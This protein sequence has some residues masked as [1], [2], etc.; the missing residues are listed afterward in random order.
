LKVLVVLG[1]LILAGLG[2]IR[3]A[4]SDPAY[5]NAP[6][7]PD[8]AIGDYPGPG[9]AVAVRRLPDGFDTARI[10][11]VALAT[12]RTRLL[13]GSLD[14]GR[15]TFVTRSALFGFPDY[16]TI[17]L[18]TEPQAGGETVVQFYARQRFGRRDHG[19]N[20]AR[21]ARWLDQLGMATP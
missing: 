10:A 7:L 9:S 14:E 6:R 13:A 1:L 2:W 12:P 19:V 16:T 21:I 4:P 18:R 17:T 8:M 15:A 20:A 5:W 11:A 3:V